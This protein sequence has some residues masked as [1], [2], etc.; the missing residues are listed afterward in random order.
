MVE[1]EANPVSAVILDVVEKGAK[2]ATQV[3]AVGTDTEFSMKGKGV[4]KQAALA[5]TEFAA[6]TVSTDVTRGTDE[7]ATGG[8]VE[9]RKRR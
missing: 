3:A 2:E 5:T 6:R 9:S 8:G 4:G 1:R 7:K